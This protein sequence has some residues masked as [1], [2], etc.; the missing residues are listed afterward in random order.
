MASVIVVGGG[1]AGLACGWRL[2]RAG[3]DVE[4]LERASAPGGRLASQWR[5]G[6]LLE[7]GA[8]FVTTSSQH[9]RDMARVLGLSLQAIEPGRT[10]ILRGGRLDRIDFQSPLAALGSRLI[11]G[12]GRVGLA[13]LALEVARHRRE[14]D[15]LRP[16]LAQ[17]LDRDDFATHLGRIV[18][19]SARDDLIA[20][21]LELVL[22]TP[23]AALSR[24]YGLVALRALSEGSGLEWLRGGLVRLSDALAERLRIRSDV[25]VLRVETQSGGAKVRYRTGGREGLAI[26]DAVVVA[27][28]ASL[29]NAMCPRLQPAERGFLDG[30]CYARSI[31]VHLL[32]DAIPGALPCEAL[33]IARSAN[34]LI[35]AV[36]ADHLR[37][38]AAPAGHGLVTVSLSGNATERLWDASDDEV[39]QRVLEALAATPAGALEP[40]ELFVRRWPYARPEFRSGYPTRLGIFR[41]RSERTPRL[42]FAGDY[43]VGPNLEGALASGLR[44][45]SEVARELPAVVVAPP[46]QRPVEGAMPRAEQGALAPTP[47]ATPPSQNA[48]APG[49]T[50]RTA[51]PR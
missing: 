17:R 28:P 35:S 51:P 44:A 27:V 5:N 24:A 19:S 11:P 40:R 16:E 12:R 48:T 37:A 30:V 23:P 41:G 49:P 13:R 9:V 34:P 38:G 31:V 45:A 10:A 29:V 22:G 7:S 4:V 21:I 47:D 1:L 50:A 3:H 8:R 25:E 6:F 20:P 36:Y 15:P 39:G 43:L 2:E 26:S 14:L 32:L 18:G 33:A 46:S 42:A